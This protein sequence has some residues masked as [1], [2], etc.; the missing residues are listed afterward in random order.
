MRQE[1]RDAL[2][3]LM[4]VVDENALPS[5][6]PNGEC[7]LCGVKFDSVDESRDP[8]NHDANCPFAVVILHLALPTCEQ[9]GCDEPVKGNGVRFC[10]FHYD[11]TL[12]HM[13]GID[14]VAVATGYKE[15]A[16]VLDDALEQAQGGKGAERHAE[17]GQPFVEQLICTL[18][19]SEGTGFPRGQA[20]KKIDET[21]R[22]ETVEAKVRELLGAINYI[23]ADV[24]VLREGT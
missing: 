9:D 21:K 15:L 5:K 24:I 8:D 23:A 20:I 22:L 14:R 1:V 13:R 17:E 12:A 7:R 6:F 3:K 4:D 19:R 2:K 16:D 18:T 11:K 10:E